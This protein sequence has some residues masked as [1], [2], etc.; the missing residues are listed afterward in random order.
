[1]S[2]IL[3]PQ[4][5]PVY[6]QRKFASAA[7]RN[8]RSVPSMPIFDGDFK[9]LIPDLDRRVILSCARAVFQDYGPITGALIQKADNSVGRAWNPKFKGEDKEWGKI[10]TDWLENQWFGAC[11]VRGRAWDFKTLLWLD[12]VAIDRDGD[13]LIY[14]T[15]SENGYPLTQRISANR[16]GM[17][18]CNNRG[19]VTEGIYKGAKISHGVIL[20]KF[21]RPIAYRILGDTQA[22]DKDLPAD[23]CI[24]SFDPLW[25]D[26]TRGMPSYAGSI[27]LIYGSMTA[28]EREQMNQ[29]IRS[30]IA[31]VEY[32]ETGGPDIDNP[33]FTPGTAADA[34]TAAQPSVENYAAGMIK[35][36]RSNSGG[37]LDVVD[38]NQPGDMWDRFQDRVVRS[39]AS[40][41]NWPYELIWKANEVNGVLVRNMQER[42]RISVEDRQ[43]VLRNPAIF[44]VRYAIAKAIKAK[45]IP[46]PKTQND[47]WKWDFQMPRKFSIDPGREAQQRRED[48]KLGIINR[49]GI[50]QEDGN[51]LPDLD[52]ERIQEVITREDKIDAAIEKRGKP[53]DR[54]LFY[55]MGP[56]EMD[57][58]IEAEATE[59]EPNTNES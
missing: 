5:N 10:A 35:Y 41:I 56:N 59:K 51:D 38:T 37:K 14:L 44:Q 21:N 2:A 32:N 27:K 36:F 49:T 17:R 19:E 48:F 34:T 46:A 31:L 29:N 33:E 3:D 6:S 7:Q 8:D 54:R 53:V 16:I 50:A 13:F 30:S 39:A 12:S 57:T 20:N 55:M 40:G 45:I 1:M 11:D 26:Q 9:D 18:G 42:A 4:G 58:T 43:D 23:K 24:H 52:D 15:E 47:W 22:E 25:H 28:T